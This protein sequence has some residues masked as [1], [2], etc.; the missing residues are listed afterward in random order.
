M[1]KRC[2]NFEKLRE[3]AQDMKK[4]KGHMGFIESLKQKRTQLNLFDSKLKES[5]D[6]GTRL[7]HCT[8]STSFSPETA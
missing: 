7:A 8:D 4:W 2:I 5:H 3:L 1:F 6:A